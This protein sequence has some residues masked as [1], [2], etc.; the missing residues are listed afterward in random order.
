MYDE[1]TEILKLKPGGYVV[2]TCHSSFLSSVVSKAIQN[3]QGHHRF[4]QED[5][6]QELMVKLLEVMPRLEAT[7][8]A[9]V[10]SLA[11]GILKNHVYD[12]NRLAKTR[13]DINAP[14][15]IAEPD[16]NFTDLVDAFTYKLGL[17]LPNPQES[18]LLQKELS[19]AITIWAECQTPRIQSFLAELINPSLSTLEKWEDLKARCPMYRQF[20]T[21]PP[22]TL[23]KFMKVPGVLVSK[24]MEDLKFHLNCYGLGLAH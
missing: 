3:L 24:A 18:A 7:S 5:L 2:S 11:L 13:N 14:L 8:E 22:S 20:D 4:D 10:L 17:V 12:M 19:R 1:G 21:I 23:G 9:E 15:P 16:F 6:S